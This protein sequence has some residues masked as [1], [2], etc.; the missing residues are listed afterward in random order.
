MRFIV[1]ALVAFPVRLAKLAE[2][3][4]VK[5]PTPGTSAC[6]VTEA[7]AASSCSSFESTG[8]T[9]KLASSLEP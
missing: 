7:I 1:I 5:L 4:L 6:E 9:V 2:R 3:G 8:R